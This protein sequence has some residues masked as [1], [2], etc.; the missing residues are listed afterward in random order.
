MMKFKKENKKTGT[1]SCSGI[2]GECDS[3]IGLSC[4]G[5]GSSKSCM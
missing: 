1:T 4:Q 3:S 2:P 5:M